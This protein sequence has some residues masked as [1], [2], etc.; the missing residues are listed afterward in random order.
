MRRAPARR[1]QRVEARDR[2]GRAVGV[3]G[4]V[5]RHAAV[6]A[7][8]PEQ[9][10]LR[11][12]GAAARAVGAGVRPAQQDRVGLET[13][14][15]VDAG[16]DVVGELEQGAEAAQQRV[17]AA[18]GREADGAVVDERDVGGERRGVAIEVGRRHH[19]RDRARRRRGAGACRAV[20][21]QLGVAFVQPRDGV[22]QAI[23]G[24]LL[25][26]PASSLR[27]DLDHDDLLE[28]YGPTSNF[29]PA[30][31]LDEHRHAAIAR[32]RRRAS[33]TVRGGT[34]DLERPAESARPE[35]PSRSYVAGRMVHA[36]VV[37]GEQGGERVGV[38]GGERGVDPSA[39]RGRR[40]RAH[41]AHAARERRRAWALGRERVEARER[42][43]VAF[44]RR[45]APSGSA[46]RRRRRPS[47]SWV[48]S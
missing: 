8:H 16:G 44:R 4:L 3:E 2:L 38:A 22:A 11:L 39:V 6:G 19:G 35:R 36:L 12:E 34:P 9:Q 28:S 25:D 45:S 18:A 24:E 31:P 37:V 32:G 47:S 7:E 46:G 17:G 29:P 33:P 20:G 21:E 26:P 13:E 14:H 48:R 30:N 10:E 5:A 42:R 40:V 41:A 23:L 15:V 43:G 1:G 27:V